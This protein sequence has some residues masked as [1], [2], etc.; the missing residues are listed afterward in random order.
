MMTAF[1]FSNT[2]YEY[3]LSGSPTSFTISNFSR[4]RTEDSELKCKGYD[5][6]SEYHRIELQ[7]SC[8]KSISNQLRRING[9][10]IQESRTRQK[11]EARPFEY[12]LRLPCANISLHFI[13]IFFYSILF[14]CD[15]KA[16]MTQS[17][18]VTLTIFHVLR[19][20]CE[21]KKNKTRHREMESMSS[22]V[23]CSHWLTHQRV[24]NQ[25]SRSSNINQLCVQNFCKKKKKIC[26]TFWI[27]QMRDAINLLNI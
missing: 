10:N 17:I 15:T 7:L 9:D 4:H 5:Y 16:N 11:Y 18:S 13:C 6:P 2:E 3:I 20:C 14:G 27:I 1:W 8:S 21:K 25:S 12:L 19:G 22:F 24:T 26:T 23:C